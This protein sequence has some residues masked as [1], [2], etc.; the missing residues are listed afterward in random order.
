MARNKYGNVKTQVDGWKFDSLVERRRY[1]ELK[2]L[3]AAGEVKAG[4]LT[5]HQPFALHAFGRDGK[6]AVIGEYRSDFT[7][8]DCTGLLVVE[9]IKGQ[10]R[11][12]DLF[13]W[14]KK[15]MLLEYGITVQEIR[16]RR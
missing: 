9:D 3:I 15:H 13:N 5:H 8:I 6:L 2:L 16:Y 14:K 1:H 4:T 11:N 7:Y 12:T 10:K